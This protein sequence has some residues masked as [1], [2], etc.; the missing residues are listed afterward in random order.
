M[1]FCFPFFAFVLSFSL[2]KKK[3]LIGSLYRN[4]LV[5]FIYQTNQSIASILVSLW[6]LRSCNFSLSFL[7]EQ[8]RFSIT[9][10]ILIGSLVTISSNFNTQSLRD[11]RETNLT[12]NRAT[13]TLMIWQRLLH[14]RNFKQ[15]LNYVCYQLALKILLTT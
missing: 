7:I 1:C 2:P 14:V 8:I 13:L 15:V 12:L 5:V 3:L 6:L 4:Y 10:I 9:P 11:T